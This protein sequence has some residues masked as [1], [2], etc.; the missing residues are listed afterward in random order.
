M[1]FL[2]K[3]QIAGG[4]K[5]HKTAL[6]GERIHEYPAGSGGLTSLIGDFQPSRWYTTIDWKS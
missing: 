5:T 4:V 3:F 6:L 1:N 2:R